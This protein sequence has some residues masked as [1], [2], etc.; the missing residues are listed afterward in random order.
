MIDLKEMYMD[1]AEEIALETYGM[2]FYNLDSWRQQ[3]VYE[4]AERDVIDGLADH[5]DNLV[6]SNKDRGMGL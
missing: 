1:R 2:E 5:A 3:R 4:Q 6:E